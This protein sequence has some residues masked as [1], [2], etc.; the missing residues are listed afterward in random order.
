MQLGE[1][2]EGEE[3]TGKVDTDPQEVQYV[4]AVGAL[5]DTN[6][7]FELSVICSRPAPR[8]MKAPLVSH[9]HWRLENHSGR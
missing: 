9:S 5:E 6:H 4:V 8:G 2:V 7:T 3:D 1:V